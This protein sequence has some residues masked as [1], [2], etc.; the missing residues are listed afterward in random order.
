MEK[1]KNKFHFDLGIPREKY[2]VQQKC[3]SLPPTKQKNDERT[4]NDFTV[5]V[6]LIETRRK[7]QGF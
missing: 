6:W 1:I 3:L 5:L 7:F 4:G 2:S